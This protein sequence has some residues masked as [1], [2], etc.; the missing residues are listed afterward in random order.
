M[1]ILFQSYH[2]VGIQKHFNVLAKTRTVVVTNSF[3]ITETF[4]NRI[5]LRVKQKFEIIKNILK[6][7]ISNKLT[8]TFLKVIWKTWRIFCS[9]PPTLPATAATKLRHC[10]QSTQK[11]KIKHTP[12][13][14]NAKKTDITFNHN[15][16]FTCFVASVLPAPDS[17]EIIIAWPCPG[18]S[19]TPYSASPV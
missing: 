1:K 16:I 7:S 4:Q 2:S 15:F 8:Q 13:N 17:P 19:V 12:R 9:I 6:I 11:R 14:L 10:K 3:G 18:P 5:T